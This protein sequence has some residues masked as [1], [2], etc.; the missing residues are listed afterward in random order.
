MWHI[1]SSPLVRK[2]F[3][4]F[5]TGFVIKLM[6]DFIDLEYD[7]VL[8]RQNFSNVLGKGVLPYTLFIFSLACFLEPST[9]ISLFFSSY[10][11][12]MTADY[13]TKMP[14]GLYGYQESLITLILGILILGSSETL[15]SL[16]IMWSVQLWD[17]LYDYKKEIACGKNYVKMLGKVECLV[18]SIICFL[19]ALYLD[20][21]KTIAVSFSAISIVY[22]IYLLSNSEEVS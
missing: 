6:D 17:D 3:A 4:V 16:F 22:I 2:L 14:S 1:T 13:G 9:S 21:V 12:G 11:I 10:I 8:K 15:S 18:F 5:L 7:T 20:A 19:S